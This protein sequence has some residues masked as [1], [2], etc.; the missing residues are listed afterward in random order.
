[1]LRLSMPALLLALA[2]CATKPPAN[3]DNLCEIFREK[4][5]WHE[6]ALKMQQRWGAPVQVPMAMMYQ[7]SSFKHDA[8]PPRYYFLGFIPWGR[9][10][11]A[12][13]YA[14]AKDETWADYKREAGGW[15]A[16]RDDFADALDFMGWYIQKSQRVNGV[17]KWD[18]YG[19]Y[20]NY[21][22]GWGGY[23]N[24]SYDAKPWL[25]NVSQKVQSRASLFG[26]QYR[27]C[28][29]EL[30]R[31]GGGRP[32]PPPTPRARTSSAFDEGKRPPSP[33]GRTG[34]LER[35]TCVMEPQAHPAQA[36]RSASG[37]AGRRTGGWPPGRAACPHLSPR[38]ASQARALA[39][40]RR[41]I[42]S[43]TVWIKVWRQKYVNKLTKKTYPDYGYFPGNAKIAITKPLSTNEPIRREND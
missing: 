27:S 39:D 37:Q 40:W 17:S 26:A 34:T 4:P 41:Q 21:H 24:R 30:S 1:M 10:S 19:Q 13:G 6:A 36:A 28:Q 5:K 14:Q 3:P 33:P 12:Y 31:G 23:R 18:A 32:P 22:E 20:L 42:S 16:S 2:G 9:V 15:G 43:S 29:Q 35:P 8:L 38:F 11:S 7:E 25:K